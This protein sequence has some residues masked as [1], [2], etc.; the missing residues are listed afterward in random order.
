MHKKF[1]QN[2]VLLTLVNF[3]VFVLVAQLIGGDALNG[4]IENGHFYLMQHGVYTEVSGWVF[5]YSEL[6][7]LSLLVL[8]PLAMIAV[9]LRKKA[10][11][12]TN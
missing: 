5:R 4:K 10:G 11:E 9:F 1:V 2:L 3:V 7:V 8:H 6:H 12:R